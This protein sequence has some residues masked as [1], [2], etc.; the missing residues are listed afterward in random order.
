MSN[1]RPDILSPQLSDAELQEKVA[2]LEQYQRAMLNILEDFKIEKAKLQDY[3]KATINILEDLNLER[4][5]MDDSQRAMINILEDFNVEKGRLEETQSATVNILEDLNMERQRMEQSQRATFNILEDLNVEKERAETANVELSHLTEELKIS[6]AELEQFAYVASHDLQEPL[7]MV[8]SYVQ[9]L[10]RRYSAR[11]NGEALEFIA[12]ATDGAN[13]M[14]I[15][16]RDLL[17]YSRVGTTSNPFTNIDTG[18]ALA[19]ALI[20]M[21]F[22]IEES[23]AIITHDELP[24]VSGDFFQIAQLFQNLIGNAMRF[25]RAGEIPNIHISAKKDVSGWIFSVRDNGIGIEREHFDRIFVIFQRLQGYEKFT[26][27]SGT[28]IG[29]SICKRIVERH[30]GRIWL[31]SESGVGTTFYFSIPQAEDD[32]SGS[33]NLPAQGEKQTSKP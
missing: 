12:F 27:D 31:E 23:Q 30:G 1:D 6:N 26:G 17:Q 2:F 32:D 8:A 29:L 22:A 24:Q 33:V 19:R 18:A 21:K 7:R 14:Q 25:C 3:Q 20:D 9:L 15:M 5:R 13:R 28:G 10:E 16:I 11:L 4:L